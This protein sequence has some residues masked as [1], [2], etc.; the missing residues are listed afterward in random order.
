MDLELFFAAFAI[1]F[2]IIYFAMIVLIVVAQW[3]IYEKANQSGWAILI[4]IYNSII[5]LR[6]IG[7][8][9]WWI[10]LFLIPLVNIVFVVWKTNLLSK[11]FGR[12]EGY[13]V[14]LIFLPYVFYPLIAF[15][16]DKYI[17]PAGSE[18]F[19]N[20]AYTN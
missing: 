19:Q 10:F 4:P 1:V 20:N 13:T 5:M 17:G 18:S 11:S 16:K 12:D 14:G 15:S 7:K 6:I 2:G 8:P 3:I 9:W